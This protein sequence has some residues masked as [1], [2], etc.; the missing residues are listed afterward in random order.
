MIVLLVWHVYLQLQIVGLIAQTRW[1][2]V[3]Q[4]EWRG[5]KVAV[6]TVLLSGRQD[7]R[8]SLPFERGVAEA[9]VA[10]SMSSHRNIVSTYHYLIQ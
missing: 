2:A 10:I 7:G 9:A 4:G 8:G 6:K 1:G 5:L 3:Y